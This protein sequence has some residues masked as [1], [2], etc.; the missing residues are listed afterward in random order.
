MGRL[1]TDQSDAVF[2]KKLI[3]VEGEYPTSLY[4]AV[5]Q[6]FMHGVHEL[7]NHNIHGQNDVVSQVILLEHH[8][9]VLVLSIP[10]M[11]KQLVM[12]ETS[13]L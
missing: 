3:E 11:H 7:C 5:L 1:V 2:I 8:I 6:H 13:S 10:A 12:H 9:T 4:G